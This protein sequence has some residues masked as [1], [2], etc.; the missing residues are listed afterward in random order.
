MKEKSDALD[1][2]RL[3]LRSAAKDL[4]EQRKSIA[5]GKER[6]ALVDEKKLRIKNLERAI[7]EE[8]N[9]DWTGRTEVDKSPAKIDL[10]GAGFTFRGPSSTLSNLPV[11]ISIDFDTD[12]PLPEN[13]DE[14]SSLVHLTRL[15][16][17]Y[18]RV[19]SLL[20]DRV[21]N[22]EN[23]IELN[24][25]KLRRIVSSCC[26]VEELEVESILEGLIAALEAYVFLSLS[27]LSFLS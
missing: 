1:R 11:G 17:W 22:V 21:A 19:I 25:L 18:E 13:K 10:V 23:G 9:F 15:N 3:L 12:P 8:D 4:S 24:E 16:M 7:S 20:K 5:L 2:T 14:V 26:G 6:V 27:I